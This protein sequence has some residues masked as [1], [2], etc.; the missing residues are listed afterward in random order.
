[1]FPA[2][3][4]GGIAAALPGGQGRRVICPALPPSLPHLQIHL[5]SYHQCVLNLPLEEDPLHALG[6]SW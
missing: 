6:L 5:C 3:A 4:S 1:M 2:A